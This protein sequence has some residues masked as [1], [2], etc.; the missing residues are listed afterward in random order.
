MICL[1]SLM[2]VIFLVA[3]GT[4]AGKNEVTFSRSWHCLMKCYYFS[5]RG[6]LAA[7]SFP[8]N[9]GKLRLGYLQAYEVWA[10]AQDPVKRRKSFLPPPGRMEHRDME[11]S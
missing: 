1:M 3:E 11:K 8:T 6:K 9:R 7:G 2:N 10:Q 4:G 5:F